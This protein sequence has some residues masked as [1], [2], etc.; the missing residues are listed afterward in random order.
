MFCSVPKIENM[1]SRSNKIQ[2]NLEENMKK[3]DM[4]P[5]ILP[6][7][8]TSGLLDRKGTCFLLFT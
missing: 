1:N 7:M 6:K 3:G 5:I 2:Q 8:P 4:L